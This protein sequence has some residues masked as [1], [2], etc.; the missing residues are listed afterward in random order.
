MDVDGTMHNYK[1]MQINVR[2]AT[3]DLMYYTSPYDT[4]TTDQSTWSAGIQKNVF[5]DGTINTPGDIDKYWS[6]EWSF[7]FEALAKESKRKESLPAADEVWFINFGRAEWNLTVT[8][9][10]KYQK[11]AEHWLHSNNSWWAWNPCGSVNLLLQ[12][13]WG[14][15]QFKRNIHDKSFHFKRWPV[16]KALFDVFDAMNA[17]KGKHGN[18]I[19]Q[20]EEL[21]IPPYLYTRRCVEIPTI[22]FNQT[23]TE[24][25]VSVKSRTLQNT[26]GHIRQDRY[27]QFD[28]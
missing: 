13:R 2:N 20:L 16:Y 27:V 17:Y 5:A 23:S 22:S 25:T 6:V 9:D 3:W 11:V 15:M 18:Y 4:N 24:F 19:D 8:A 10:N 1:Q 21:D 26:I 28:T 7:T 12:N 14:L